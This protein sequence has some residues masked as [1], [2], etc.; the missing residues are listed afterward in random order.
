MLTAITIRNNPD[1][2]RFEVL[3]GGTVIGQAAYVDDGGAHRI[4]YHTV[5]DEEYGGQGLAG[6]LAAQALDE[7]VADGLK[8]VPVC[9]FIKKYLGKNTRYAAGV[10]RPTT[11]LLAVLNA[12]LAQRARR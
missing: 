12:A 5:I 9:P 11:A 8:I 4:F 2:T 7:T 1:R 3:D 6:R 10:Q